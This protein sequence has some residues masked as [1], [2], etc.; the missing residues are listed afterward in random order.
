MKHIHYDGVDILASDDVADAVIEYAAALAATG[1]ADTI[2]VPTSAP[3]GSSTTIKILIGPSS[4]L[5]VEDADD[6]DLEIESPEFVGRL[7]AAA[8]SF[9]TVGPVHAAVDPAFGPG[10]LQSSG[11]AMA[12]VAPRFGGREVFEFVETDVA[13][14]EAGEV[15]IRVRAAGVNPAD[16]KH[17][18]ASA[19]D[20]PGRLP[21]RIGYEVAGTIAAIGPDT[22]IASGG[23][24]VGDD[25]LA[26]RITGGYATA[27]TV[28]AA[29]VF[30]KPE[31][32]GFA[33]AANLLLAGSTA[34][35][36]L[37]VAGVG[38]GDAVLVHGA[39]GAVGVSVL[40]QAAMLGARV[41]GT[42]SEDS[43][44]VVRQ[45]GGDAVVYGPGLA[46]RV[47]AIVPDGIDAALDCV[48]TDEAVDVSLELV[49]DRSR[50]VTI[51]APGR[52]HDEGFRAIAGSLPDSAAFRDS[53]RQRLVDVAGAGELVVPLARTFP[54]T[55]AVAALGLLATGH[56][57]GKV[58][59][60]P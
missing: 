31:S 5:I 13:P 20:D 48:G 38:P 59:L 58:A 54:L 53:V 45:F 12:W 49:A 7:Q 1:R 26:F 40:Q 43:G 9:G 55:E 15:T 4:E 24:A 36:M 52:A 60:V 3:D 34:A 29:D 39:S 56:P 22:V 8:R 33:E 47:R 30:A 37:H 6:D 46:D 14:P 27:V 28:P 25:V 10:G 32:L 17:T 18:E 42:S 50:I 2:P 23:G 41:V 44:H 11:T 57:G 21:I 16:Q 35:E 19:G 51:A